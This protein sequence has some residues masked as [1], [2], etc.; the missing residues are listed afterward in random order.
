M[1]DNDLFVS[2]REETYES[3]GENIT[4]TSAHIQMLLVSA[5]YGFTRGQ[6]VI[7]RVLQSYNIEWPSEYLQNRLYWLSRGAE[8]GCMIARSDLMSIDSGLAQ[9][10]TASFRISETLFDT[11]E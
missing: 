5:E 11:A 3:I 10:A 2:F 6:A 8:A 1:G 4:F 9:K 7:N